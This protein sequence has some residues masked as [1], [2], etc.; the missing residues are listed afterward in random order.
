MGT[1]LNRVSRTAVACTLAVATAITSVSLAVGSARATPNPQTSVGNAGHLDPGL[2]THGTHGVRVVVTARNGR[3]ADARRATQQAK[4]HVGAALPIV[5][6]FAATVPANQLTDLAADP[7]VLAVT[8]DRSARLDSIS[9]DSGALKTAS[10]FI[11]ATGA[12]QAWAQGDL[13]SGVGVAVID[14]GVSDVNDL[15]GRVIHGP[16]LSGEGTSIDSFGHGTVMGGLIAGNGADSGDRRKGGYTGVAPRANV[17]AVKVAGRNA[18]V[19]VSTMLQAMHWVAAYKDQFN[20]RVM[21]LSWGVRSTQDPS[22]DPL[23]YAVERLWQLGIVVVTA[24]G[25]GGPKPGTIVKPGDDPLVITVGAVDD[26]G[27]D[28]VTNDKVPRW[29][30]RGPTAA[31]LTKPDVVAPGRKV[32]ATRSFG[33]WIEQNFPDALVGT[34]YIRGSGTSEA[35]AVVSGVAALL[36]AQRPDLTPDQVKYLLTSTAAPLPGLTSYDEGA[37]KVQLGAALAASATNAPVQA[38]VATGTGSIEASRGS[39]HV[40][41]TC[42]GVLVPIVGEVDAHCEPW[43]GTTWTGTTW[44]G[45]SWTGATWT[46]D[47]WTPAVWT[48]TTW[49]GGTWTGGAWSGTVPW[50]GTTWTGTT[51]TGTTWT[52]T[53]WTGTTWTGGLWAGTTWTGF[54]VVLPGI[55]PEDEFE[56]AF[57][58]DGPKAGHDLPGEKTQ[59]PVAP[60]LAPLVVSS[61]W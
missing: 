43:D 17:I 47:A 25:N 21:N 28:D 12:D 15:A 2:A 35:T 20:I 56:T 59:S 13:G 9:A 60:T 31:G 48:G 55:P 11:H 6:G 24:A 7:S 44:T 40:A 46:S 26:Q 30:S 61:L 14:T 34:S 57:W 3:V 39:V 38:P 16:D 23:D 45:D 1:P 37:G 5:A 54:G 53:T 10:A 52:G 51:W 58:G 50:T 8:A 32:I 18:S 22:V 29:S 42:A 27:D 19:D 41:T 33:S 4:G 49:T 36:V